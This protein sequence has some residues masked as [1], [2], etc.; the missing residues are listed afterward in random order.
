MIIRHS[1]QLLE[2]LSQVE[3]NIQQIEKLMRDL[4]LD[5]DSEGLLRTLLAKR[6]HLSLGQQN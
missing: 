5:V 6:Y 2:Q 3:E 1:G 4:E